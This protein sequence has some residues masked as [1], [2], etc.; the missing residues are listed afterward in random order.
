MELYMPLRLWKQP[1]KM[2]ILSYFV[3]LIDHGPE[4]IANYP[5]HMHTKFSHVVTKTYCHKAQ[6]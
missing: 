1:N 6:L 5:Y 2:T 3:Y 4:Q